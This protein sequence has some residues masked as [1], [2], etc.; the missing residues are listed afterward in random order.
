MIR[1]LAILVGLG[2]VLVS[3]IS[4]VFGFAAWIGSEEVETAELKH[5]KH[6]HAPEEGFSFTGPFG[7]FDRQQ[8]Q[9]GFRVYQEVCAGCHSLSYVAFRNLEDLGYSEAEV[10]AIADRWPLQV[11][12][13]NPET[14]EPATR[15]AIPADNFPSPYP[16]ETAA[17]AANNN[18]IPPD[19][20]LIVKARENGSN[21]VYSL[22]TGY[23][24]PPAD[25][26]VPQGLHYN[27]YFHSIKIAMPKP[28]TA[29]GQVTYEDGTP[30]T[31]H[32]MATDVTAFLT[33]AAEPNLERRHQMGLAVLIFL[34]GATFLA[35][36]AYRS[37]WADRKVKKKAKRTVT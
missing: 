28:I 6:A 8:L 36:L 9:R 7:H 27:P 4:F 25:V 16:N 26:E 15:K 37:V 30:A 33:W 13:I 3:A 18:A 34:I 5:H 1:F 17:R 11:P 10:R 12:S 20:S 21:Y 29:D 14:G 22:L 32:Q 19:L 35:Y 23:E 2:F 24:N 31:V